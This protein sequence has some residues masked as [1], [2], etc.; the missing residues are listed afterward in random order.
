MSALTTQLW[1]A[2]A[3]V[4]ERILS[5]PFLE[6]LAAGTLDRAAFRFYVIQD[7]HYIREFT[8][9]LGIV[10]ARAPER[11]DTAM[12]TRRAGDLAAEHE[13]HESLLADLDVDAAEVARTPMAPTTLT[14]TS[15]LLAVAQG[16]AFPDALAALLACPWIYWEVGKTLVGKGSTDE[17]YGRWIERYGG[18]VAAVNVP[19]FLELADRVGADLTPTQRAT[20]VR[21]FT[22]GCKLEWMF[23]DMG[24]HQRGWPI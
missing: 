14:Y 1:D 11:R 15:W 13:L 9:V 4:F 3:P 7:V 18:E 24:Y 17:L 6:E 21:H 10:A 19:P 2:G 5:H 12:L 8:R 20:A 22:T 23:W 16:G